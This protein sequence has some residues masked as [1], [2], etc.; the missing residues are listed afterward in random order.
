MEV[1][2]SRRA[3]SYLTEIFQFMRFLLVYQ[4]P[5]QPVKPA[6]GQQITTFPVSQPQ[7][8]VKLERPYQTATE[9]IHHENGAS[10]RK[11]TRINSQPTNETKPPMRTKRQEHG[12]LMEGL[13]PVVKRNKS[14]TSEQDEDEKRRNFLERNRQGQS[15]W[16]HMLLIHQ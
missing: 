16:E 9:F 6:P 8:V 5:Q 10:S 15:Y 11:G 7:P 4:Q 12:E 14:V 13:G 1:R 3:P 2:Y